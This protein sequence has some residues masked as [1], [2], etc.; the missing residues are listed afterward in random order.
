MVSGLVI[1]NFALNGIELSLNSNIRI[2]G[3]YIGTNATGTTDAGNTDNGVY[4]HASSHNNSV[5][6][7]SAADRNVISGND[8]DG[9]SIGQPGSTSNTVLGNYIGLK[10]DGSATAIGNSS[11][12][13]SIWSSAD[14]NLVGGTA[15]TTKNVISGNNL[16]V[17]VDSA[18]SNTIAGNYIGTRYTGTTAQANT[19]NGIQVNGFS[20]ATT[21]GGTA[22]VT[23]GGP[24]TGA[25][26]VISGNSSSG[27]GISGSDATVTVEGNYIG[28]DVNGTADVGNGNAGIFLTSSAQNNTIGGSSPE[29]R[30]II[31]GNGGHGVDFYNNSSVNTLIGNY[32]GTNVLG[33]AAIPNSYNGVSISDD[34]HNN[35]IGGNTGLTKGGSCTG[36]C[37]LIS[38]NTTNG[39]YFAS[40]SGAENTIE[41]NY[42]G[43]NAEGIA[44]VSNGNEG[45]NVSSTN[46]GSNI[47]N[48]LLSGNTNT[49]FNLISGSN[50]RIRS[51]YIGLNAAGTAV[52]QNGGGPGMTQVQISGDNNIFGGVN[53]GDGNII[54]GNTAREVNLLGLTPF[55]GN[56]A[57]YNMFFGNCIGT[58]GDCEPQSGFGA[59]DTG[60]FIGIDAQNNLVGAPL[61]DYPNAGNTIAGNGSGIINVGVFGFYPANNSFLG[62]RI[63]NNTGGTTSTIGIDNLQTDN[64]VDYINQNV[65]LNDDNDIDYNGTNTGPNHYLNF[66]GITSVTSTSNQATITYNLDINDAEVGATGYRVEFFANDSVDPSG[67]GQGQTYLGSDTVSGDVTGRQATI[68]LPAGVSG[69]KFITATTTMTTDQT[70][71]GFGHTSEF[72]ADVQATLAPVD[73][74]PVPTPSNILANTGQNLRWIMLAAAT[75]IL[76]GCTGLYFARRKHKI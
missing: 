72:A 38:G 43:T 36:S 67:Y 51:N 3:N 44:A 5:G 19:T 54:A 69:D 25:C 40:D 70:E 59:T 42:I 26:N 52:L 49:G 29:S 46:L 15:V 28:T 64:F 22:D 8:N 73:P 17:Y 31:S 60:L 14:D 53:E 71:T 37:N 57:E 48:N 76:I 1:N 61:E 32:I 56:S 6:G 11:N 45:I 55:G 41:G 58:N 62:N 34:A 63:Y 75:L 39:I 30:N 12:G 35:N 47:L 21:I 74:V 16:G 65:T 13:V 18:S 27:V 9:V 66:P 10:A 50:F 20:S 33:T 68:T 2:I 7:I 24:C 23:V 4:I